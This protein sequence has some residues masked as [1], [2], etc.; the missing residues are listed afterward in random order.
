MCLKNIVT[1]LKMIAEDEWQI[2]NLI[3][4]LTA[5]LEGLTITFEQIDFG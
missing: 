2:K 1:L 3:W 5:L 4:L